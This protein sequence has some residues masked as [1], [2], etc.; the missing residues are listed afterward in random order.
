MSEQE[1]LNHVKMHQDSQGLSLHLVEEVLKK[2]NYNIDNIS[3]IVIDIK[4]L[5]NPRG[6]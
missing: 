2:R 6:S 5:C 4:K 1:V 3:V